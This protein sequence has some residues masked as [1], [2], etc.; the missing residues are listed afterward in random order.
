[1]SIPWMIFVGSDDL[2]KGVVQLKDLGAKVQEAIP[3]DR[4]VEELQLRL[5]NLK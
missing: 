3:R 2:E 4:V 5:G 1:M